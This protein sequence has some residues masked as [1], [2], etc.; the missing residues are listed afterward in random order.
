MDQLLSPEEVAKIL[1]LNPRT[2]LRMIERGELPATKVARRWRVKE[3][4]LQ[5]YIDENM[6]TK[7]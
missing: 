2:I 4:D 7:E 3:I 6:N 5:N 1:A